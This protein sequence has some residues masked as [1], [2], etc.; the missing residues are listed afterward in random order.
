MAWGPVEA[1]TAL[2]VRLNSNGMLSEIEFPQPAKVSILQRQLQAG[3]V[4]LAAPH[5]PCT[6]A[7]TPPIVSCIKVTRIRDY[8][9]GSQV[10]SRHKY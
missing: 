7:S 2:T 8:D 5:N 4:L 6:N 10:E 3:Q 9:T 1:R